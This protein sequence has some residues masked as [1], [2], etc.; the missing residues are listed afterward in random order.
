M[1]DVLDGLAVLSSIFSM[2]YHILN[3]GYSDAKPLIVISQSGRR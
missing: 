3:V 1:Y 2:R